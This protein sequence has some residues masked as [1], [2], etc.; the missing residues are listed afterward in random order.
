MWCTH[1]NTR[2]LLS[3]TVCYCFGSTRCECLFFFFFFFVYSFNGELQTDNK[4]S[5][6]KSSPHIN[7]TH[8]KTLM[9]DENENVAFVEG[10]HCP[11]FHTRFL[12]SF[13]YAISGLIHTYSSVNT[14]LVL[15]RLS[16]MFP[17]WCWTSWRRFFFFCFHTQSLPFHG[18]VAIKSYKIGLLCCF[19]M[20][21]TCPRC[22]T[23]QLEPE[24][25][26]QHNARWFD[27]F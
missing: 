5:I 21:Q 16:V 8:T 24:E 18:I 26:L 11:S 4:A 25:K 20:C 15:I 7:Q 23:N 1:V 14:D 6:D 10:V 27:S 22:T 3:Q 19:K 17:M 9:P 13:E 12:D 2:V